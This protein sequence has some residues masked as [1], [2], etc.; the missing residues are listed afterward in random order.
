MAGPKKRPS[1]KKAAAK[2]S[3]AARGKRAAKRASAATTQDPLAIP[4]STESMSQPDEATKAQP[5]RPKRGGKKAAKSTTDRGASRA[6]ASG[7]MADAQFVF[8]GIVQ[9]RGAATFDEVP[10]TAN[11]L[12]VG[13]EEILISPD[14]LR[15]FEQSAITVQ[16]GEGQEVEVGERYVFYTNGWIYGAGLAVESVAVTPDTEAEHS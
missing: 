3:S 15:D 2:R 9:E 6:S 7:S 13:V 14:V 12:V 1:A 10:L 16:L 8:R 5:G 11:T 4:P